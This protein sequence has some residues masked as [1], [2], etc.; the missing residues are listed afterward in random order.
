MRARTI[1]AETLHLHTRTLWP[2]PAGGQT[3]SRWR[4]LAMLGERDLPLAKLVEPHYDALAIL[5]DLG[6]SRDAAAADEVW[7]VWAAEP[8]FAV[9]EAEQRSDGWFLSG[10]KAFCSGAA[11]VTH[12]LVTVETTDGAR[13]FAVDVSERGV[14]TAPDDHAWVGSGMARA[15]TATLVFDDV[16]AEPVGGPGA[17]VD[18]AGFWWGAIGV[19]AIWFGGARGVAGVLEETQKRLDPHGLAHLGAVRA[20][21][22]GLAM[23]FESA[24]RSADEDL[25]ETS[26][27]ERLA[28][29]VR[30]R[31]SEVVDSVLRHVDRAL[32]PAPLAFDAEHSAR[33]DDLRVFVRQH[34]A[35]R[36]LEQLGSLER[37][38]D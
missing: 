3:A 24:A 12:A 37:E 30:Q 15:A 4:Q 35:E 33:V 8:P 22:E 25:L 28:L 17:Y 26:A 31:T 6:M 19:A 2:V 14:T 36:D 10:R 34:H 13:L 20:D 5:T 9:L 32:G 27:V 1:D 7:A 11:L 16:S 23:V 38:D 18:R 21:L 29:V